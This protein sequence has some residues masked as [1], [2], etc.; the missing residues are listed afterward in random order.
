MRKKI[1]RKVMDMIDRFVVLLM[2]NLQA[3]MHLACLFDQLSVEK[4]EVELKKM[5]ATVVKDQSKIEDT[6]AELDRYK[7]AA[8]ETTW[9]KVNGY[10]DSLKRLLKHIT[11]F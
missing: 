3:L 8:L 9:E 10:V 7:R 2:I 11:K 6:I 5:M 1:N 4:K